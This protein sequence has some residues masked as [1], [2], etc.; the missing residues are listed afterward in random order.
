M[1]EQI[2][3]FATLPPDALSHLERHTR[4]QR[5][6]RETFLMG[7][8]E[9]ADAM[10]LI[11][12]GS[13]KVFLSDADGKEVRLALLSA[14]DYA[15]EMALIDGQP[16][17]ASVVTAEESELCVLSKDGFNQCLAEHPDIARHVMVA[18][19]QRLRGADRK[20]SSL[21]LLD[22]YGRIAQLLLE[23]GQPEGNLKVI[24]ERLSQQEIA[25]RVGASREMVSKIMKDLAQSGH[26]AVEKK[27]I[28]I[29]P[30]LMPRP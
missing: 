26:I 8:G 15:G 19:V 2:P 1:L 13:V 12:S 14:G 22:V 10:Y 11:L 23:L 6:A 24:G 30:S 4:R 25:N 16:R 3:L 20:I 17:S 27:R 5:Y 28:V 7:V 21:A 18:L 9:R 29:Y